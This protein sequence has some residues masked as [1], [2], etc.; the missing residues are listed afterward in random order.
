M[1]QTKGGNRKSSVAS[2]SLAFWIS[3]EA[4]LTR[5]LDATGELIRQNVRTTAGLNMSQRIHR[6]PCKRIETRLAREFKAPLLRLLGQVIANA[7]RMIRDDY[8]NLRS[9]K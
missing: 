6:L 3:K 8:H 2:L 4:S 7:V 5:L 9:A 1:C